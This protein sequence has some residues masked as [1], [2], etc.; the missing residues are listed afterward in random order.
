MSEQNTPEAAEA[1]L[2]F[3]RAEPVKPRDELTYDDAGVPGIYAVQLSPKTEPALIASAALDGFHEK[4]P[5]E[6]I[7]DFTYTVVDESGNTLD[8]H[9]D[10]DSYSLSSLCVD[11]EFHDAIPVPSQ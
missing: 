6:V 1:V 3:V 11:V 8:E 10:H 9:P 5:V 4:V 2:V 7:D